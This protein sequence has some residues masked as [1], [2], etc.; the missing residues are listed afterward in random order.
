MANFDILLTPLGKNPN[1]IVERDMT[2]WLKDN[3]AT[4]AVLLTII[5]VAV[6]FGK[7]VGTIQTQIETMTGQIDTLNNSVTTINTNLGDLTA[8]V[9]DNSV[10]IATLRN[11]SVAANVRDPV[12][13][14]LEAMR[15]D[16]MNIK[17]LLR[18][19]DVAI[20]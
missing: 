17:E 1:W 14:E 13:E 18:N 15:G 16:L 8:S 2:T 12:L 7:G 10:A 20:P 5:G 4:L 6:A 11:S 9:N 3:A 19:Q